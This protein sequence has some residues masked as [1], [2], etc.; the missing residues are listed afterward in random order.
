VGFKISIQVLYTPL[1]VCSSRKIDIYTALALM[2]GMVEH[3]T[4][5]FLGAS[6]ARR[7]K[8]GIFGA[9]RKII[10]LIR[11]RFQ[12]GRGPLL[13]GAANDGR[14]MSLLYPLKLSWAVVSL[15]QYCFDLNVHEELSMCSVADFEYFSPKKL[16]SGA[17]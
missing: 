12:E 15:F 1:A 7:I 3:P 4:I 14:L 13:Y 9:D 5:P 8:Y 2:C 11:S 16:H 6:T 10:S 17:L